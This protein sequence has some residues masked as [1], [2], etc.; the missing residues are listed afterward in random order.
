MP[1]PPIVE[2]QWIKTESDHIRF[3][4]FLPKQIHKDLEGEIFFFFAV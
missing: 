1:K 3:C 2:I 4:A